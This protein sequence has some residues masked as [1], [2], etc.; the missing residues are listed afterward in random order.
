[1]A[2]PTK[3]GEAFS[4]AYLKGFDSY[5]E[6]Q[7]KR[8]AEREEAKRLR[9]RTAKAK[10]GSILESLA[11]LSQKPEDPLSQ[12][13][14]QVA[15]AEANVD[16]GMSLMDRIR[17]AAPKGRGAKSEYY[18]R[19]QGAERRLA[20]R[21]E[22]IDAQKLAAE[23]KIIAEEE[24]LERQK[25]IDEAKFSSMYAVQQR[26]QEETRKHGAKRGGRVA[27]A[28]GAGSSGKPFSVV[29]ETVA[30]NNEE[31]KLGGELYNSWALGRAEYEKLS[32]SA[33]VHRSITHAL[34]EVDAGRTPTNPHD[35]GTDD[36]E[37]WREMVDTALLKNPIELEK[38]KQ[39]SVA[40]L[41]EMQ[42]DR[43]NR[44]KFAEKD[45]KY[46]EAQ[47]RFDKWWAG[48]VSRIPT[49]AGARPTRTQIIA[50]AVKRGIDPAAARTGALGRAGVPAFRDFNYR[51]FEKHN[52]GWFDIAE[53]VEIKKGGKPVDYGV[54][55]AAL[56]AIE[57][58]A[59]AGLAEQQRKDRATAVS[60]I[61]LH[62][63]DLNAIATAV[64]S[65][66]RSPEIFNMARSIINENRAAAVVAAGGQVRGAAALDDFQWKEIEKKRGGQVNH[67][68]QDLPAD[69][70]R[71][72]TIQTVDG[73]KVIDVYTVIQRNPTR[74]WT[75]AMEFAAQKDLKQRTNWVIDPSSP[76]DAK[77][78]YVAGKEI[79]IRAD[80]DRIK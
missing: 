11:G 59:E 5:T 14:S 78:N 67:I 80:D 65:N 60:L 43:N 73:P 9:K 18:S 63:A 46:L 39:A 70:P 57:K 31:A 8:D 7:L 61:D 25:A 22:A 23:A 77:G 68:L 12:A 50:E 34:A 2:R 69:E 1:M 52:Q 47:T 3:F 38:A 51:N 49:R 4:N 64:A 35:P 37:V 44:I 40:A 20:R 17:G 13:F 79:W 71:Q 54:P 55:F 26:K 21:P 24:V 53:Q 48:V 66:P 76:K 45:P 33:K 29:I 30:D 15:G 56:G 32:H 6:A 36:H 74:P 19:L 10:F 62:G 75:N 72:I 41:V 27:L 42:R 28:K 58:G 16:P